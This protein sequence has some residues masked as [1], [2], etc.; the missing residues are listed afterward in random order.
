MSTATEV[1]DLVV[2][3]ARYDEVVP[4]KTAGCESEARH[5][6]GIKHSKHAECEVTVHYP[7]CDRCRTA[8]WVRTYDLVAEPYPCVGCGTTTTDVTDYIQYDRTL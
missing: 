4:C 7:A 8:L 3:S 2:L 1:D 6:V 5:A